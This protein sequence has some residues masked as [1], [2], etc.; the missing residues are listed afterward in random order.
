MTRFYWPGHKKFVNV[1][2]SSCFVRQ[3]R[4]NPKKSR[5]RFA[6]WLPSFP[7]THSGIDNLG[8]LPVSNGKSYVALFRIHFTK[9][10]EV[11]PLADQTAETTATALLEY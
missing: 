5:H 10:S 9:R 2:V 1:S 3:Q 11:V 6:N 4:N 7:I 8:P